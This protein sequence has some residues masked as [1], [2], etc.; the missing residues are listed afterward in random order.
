MVLFAALLGF[1]PVQGEI[2]SW[3]DASGRTHYSDQKPEDV[4]AQS[5]EL[6]INTI[7]SPA[8]SN[9]DFL[10]DR[11]R[12]K[13][14][15][16]SAEWCGVC[17]KARHYFQK[18]GIAF[19]EYDIETSRKG[20]RDYEAL[21]GRGVPIILVGSKRMDGFSTKRFMSLYEGSKAR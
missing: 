5:L 11:E 20:R 7:T 21:N 18:Q 19:N 2:Y 4:S 16:Y 17:K 14:V 10:D 6:K 8:V 3:K 1:S 15:M 9:S 13:V 12:G